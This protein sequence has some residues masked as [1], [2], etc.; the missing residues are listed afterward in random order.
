M[1]GNVQEATLPRLFW[2]LAAATTVVL[3]LGY[4]NALAVA[5]GA[6]P[7]SG[8]LLDLNREENIPATFSMLLLF[9]T[10]AAMLRVAHAEF[11]LKQATAWGWLV[12][13]IGFIYLGI[14]ERI[15]LHE[16]L[17]IL[18]LD[19]F[20]RYSWVVFAIPGV[21]VTALAC[22]PF[23]R[24]LPRLTAVRLVAA[25]AT[26]VLGA[27]GVEMW[28]AYLATNGEYQP[29]YQLEVCIEESL[30]MIGVLL[31]LR[32]VLLHFRGLS[33]SPVS[34]WPGELAR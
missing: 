23:L 28:G 21:I 4:A 24:H 10:A 33:A 30:E 13:G 11:R 18:N 25:G 17:D 31:G 19:G 3:L 2:W 1:R 16:R 15:S 27:V 32:A 34:A 5:V 12:L 9:I 20:L 6:G 7:I 14:D 26:F 8:D 29:L 22:I